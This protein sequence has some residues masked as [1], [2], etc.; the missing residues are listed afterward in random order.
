MAFIANY[1]QN[2]AATYLAAGVT[3]AGSMA[4]NAV[5]GVGSL[6]ENG[7]RSFGEGSK[8]PSTSH[9]PSSS[10]PS[11]RRLH[12]RAPCS[13]RARFDQLFQASRAAFH[14]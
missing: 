12:S 14:Q 4:G 13:Q 9:I 2:T 8:Q 5:G 6:I 7:G 11:I 3:A 1:V 10:I